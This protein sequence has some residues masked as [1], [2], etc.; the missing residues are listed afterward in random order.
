MKHKNIKDKTED[1]K[2]TATKYYLKNK[3]KLSM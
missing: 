3:E 2:I 1:Y